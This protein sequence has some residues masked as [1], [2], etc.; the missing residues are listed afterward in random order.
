MNDTTVGVLLIV[1]GRSRAGQA[2]VWDE[3][4]VLRSQGTEVR[5]VA[6]DAGVDD[7]LAS[8][9][10]V[11]TAGGSGTQVFVEQGSVQRRRASRLPVGIELIDMDEVAACLL[12]PDWMTV[13]R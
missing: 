9:Q 5:I 13:W 8:P 2:S 10:R 4:E 7:V 3:A 6:V 12:D 11:V 1:D